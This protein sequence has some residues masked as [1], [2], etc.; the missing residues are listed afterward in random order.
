MPEN[1]V[2]GPEAQAVAAFVAKYAG[3]TT[4]TGG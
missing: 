2:T 1:I 3:R 4:A